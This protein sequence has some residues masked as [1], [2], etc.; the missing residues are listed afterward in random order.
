MKKTLII[1]VT[2]ILLLNAPSVTAAQNS[3]EISSDQA[4]CNISLQVGQTISFKMS[5]SEWT[6]SAWELSTIDNEN[7]LELQ[8]VVSAEV[9][10]PIN[11]WVFKAVQPG[12]ANLIFISENEDT[13]LISVRR[14]CIKIV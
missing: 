10:P 4:N 9:N 13:W 12:T 6:Q 14:Y 2:T 7:I 5:P 8:K 1:L 3:V 11:C